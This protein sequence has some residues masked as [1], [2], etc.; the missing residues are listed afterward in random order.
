MIEE[1]RYGGKKKL[2]EREVTRKVYSKNFV[3]MG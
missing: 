2:W 3:Q 1:V